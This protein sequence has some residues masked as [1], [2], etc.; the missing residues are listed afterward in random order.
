VAF[1]SRTKVQLVRV[2]NGAIT[3]TDGTRT[4]LIAESAANVAK[5]PELGCAF[6]WAFRGFSS[7]TKIVTRRIAVNIAKLP[8]C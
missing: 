6:V 1:V 8:G 4:F 3:I 5:L 7:G 2:R